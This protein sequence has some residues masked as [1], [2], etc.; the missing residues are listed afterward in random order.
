LLETSNIDPSMTA[1]LF[2]GPS[3]VDYF[4]TIRHFA[5]LH[6]LEDSA[7]SHS[8]MLIRDLCLPQFT[9]VPLMA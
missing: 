6:Q 5:L 2:H 4:D 3:W 1:F 7:V 8:L 9:L